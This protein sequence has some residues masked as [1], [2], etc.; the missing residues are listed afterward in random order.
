MEQQRALLEAQRL[1]SIEDVYVQEAEAHAG[2]GYEPLTPPP[3]FIVQLRVNPSPH[4]AT[5][6][7]EADGQP[8]ASVRYSVETGLRLLMLEADATKE[9][10]PAEQIIAEIS[11]NFVVR[12]GLVNAATALT[13]EQVSAFTENAL[14]HL[15]PYWREFLH[16]TAA[17]LRLPAVVL[18]MKAPRQNAVAQDNSNETEDQD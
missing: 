2:P 18:P 4:V 17:R 15:W 5:L 1:L 6:R 10:I 12:Y 8:R 11:A 16:A 14:F 9:E 7:Y 3:S 13:E